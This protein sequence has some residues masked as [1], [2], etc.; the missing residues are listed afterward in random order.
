MVNSV[1]QLVNT[2]KLSRC[3]SRSETGEFTTCKDLVF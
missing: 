3:I 1:H 2:E